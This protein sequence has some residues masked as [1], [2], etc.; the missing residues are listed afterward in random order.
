MTK[1]L[2]AFTFLFIVLNHSYAQ[3]KITDCDRILDKEINL[4]QIKNNLEDFKSDFKTFMLCK[5]DT[6]DYQILLG[7]KQDMI[8]WSLNVLSTAK[9]QNNK[10]SYTFKDLYDFISKFKKTE[11]YNI[12]REIVETRNKLVVKT[13]SIE[14]WEEDRKS[15]EII[16]F[17]PKQIEII[18]SIVQKND[19]ELTYDGIFEIAYPVLI[20]VENKTTEKLAQANNSNNSVIKSN[21]NVVIMSRIHTSD[22]RP[23]WYKELEKTTLEEFLEDFK[24]IDWD[25]EYWEESKNETYNYPDIEAIN[26]DNKLYLSFSVSELTSESFQFVIGLG[27]HRINNR[28]IK[29]FATSSDDEARVINIIKLFFESDLEKLSREIKTLDFLYE[30]TDD[31]HNIESIDENNLI[32]SCDYAK[33]LWEGTYTFDFFDECIECANF[34]E[35]PILFFFSSYGSLECTEF[36]AKILNDP[37]IE[38]LTNSKYVFVSMFTDDVGKLIEEEC[39]Y[40]E[41]QKIYVTTKGKRNL[42]TQ[43]EKFNN[44]NQPYFVIVDSQGA[45]LKE[46][47]GGLDIDKFKKFLEK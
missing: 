7:P 27:I 25:S 31:F 42:D 39:Y 33:E 16:R 46:Y 11:E 36:S 23:T 45:V 8:E 1:L 13:A 43:I 35:R 29:L 19:N 47:S 41:I 3:K 38:K 40:S 12:V 32:S 17:N 28:I 26:L 10:N 18:K 37:E 24:N 20:E 5:F 15:L 22:L 2:L 44:R 4:E 6:I 34:L 30:A 14:N 9:V 21:E